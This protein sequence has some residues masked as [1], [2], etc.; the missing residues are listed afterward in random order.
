MKKRKY[1]T[2]ELLDIMGAYL[3]QIKR[4]GGIM[5]EAVIDDIEK[6][7]T[8]VLKIY[9]HILL[10]AWQGFLPVFLPYF[11]KCTIFSEK[12]VENCT[13]FYGVLARKLKNRPK[14]RKSRKALR[15]SQGFESCKSCEALKVVN[16]ATPHILPR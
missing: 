7:I 15:K 11:A 12:Q 1:T 8:H 3:C 16:R 10:Y 9:G 6:S 14:S 5:P 2:N 4:S 13:L